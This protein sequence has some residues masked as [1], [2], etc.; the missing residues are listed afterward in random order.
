[1]VLSIFAMGIFFLGWAAQYE[2]HFIKYLSGRYGVE[3]LAPPKGLT[4]LQ[5][6]AAPI[7]GRSR[8]ANLLGRIYCGTRKFGKTDLLICNEARIDSKTNPA[9][10]RAFPGK[11]VLLVRDLVDT[12]FLDEWRADFDA[13]YSFDYEQ[14]IELG[15][16]YMNQFMPVGY[17]EL[18]APAP[19]KKENSKP[20]ALFIGR[21]KGRGAMLIGLADAL[22]NCGCNVDFRILAD[23]ST[24]TTTPY[25][26]T[27][28]IDYLE[29]LEE[30]LKADVLVEI[31]QPGQSGFTLR[32]LEAA[33]YGKKLIT[34]N[35]A[36]KESPLYHPHNVLI[37]GDR[38]QWTADLFR[39]F[40]DLPLRRVGRET[41]YEYSPDFMLESLIKNHGK[42]HQFC[43]PDDRDR[44][45]AGRMRRRGP[46]DVRV[47]SR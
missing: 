45:K 37:V 4:R 43:R 18:P 46:A 29:L 44:L 26:I 13:I 34:D 33:Y 42:A 19:L 30:T 24:S 39:D 3:H 22:Q 40:L 7:L 14:C 17:Q 10:I 41:L 15:M 36:I 1:M 12:A 27:S 8:S 20:T 6:I 5:Q 2:R 35:Q 32:T 11:K 28:K 23:E 25:H 9:I 31:N 21:E 47:L 16:T 38:E